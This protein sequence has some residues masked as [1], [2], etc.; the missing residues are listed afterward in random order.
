MEFVNV[1]FFKVVLVKLI[2]INSIY[3]FENIEIGASS[4][5]SAG[6]NLKIYEGLTEYVSKKLSNQTELIFRKRYKD[7]NDLTQDHNLDIAFVCTGVYELLNIN[8]MLAAPQVVGRI[9][10]N[11]V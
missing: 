4:F 11:S 9:S 7:I 2:V 8:N 3:A 10:Y 5:V 1:F 6:M